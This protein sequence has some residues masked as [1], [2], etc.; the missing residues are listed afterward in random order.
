MKEYEFKELDALEIRKI[1]GGWLE[2][3]GVAIGIVIGLGEIAE[4]LGETVGENFK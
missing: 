1:N 3:L 4:K 2:P